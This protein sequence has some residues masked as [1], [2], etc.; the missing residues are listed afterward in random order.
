[1]CARSGTSKCEVCMEKKI[2]LLWQ[3]MREQL[4]R[5]YRVALMDFETLSESRQYVFKPLTILLVLLVVFVG[6][7]GGT[8]ALIVL[9]PLRE[10]IPGYFKSEYEQT[11]LVQRRL[12]DSL[13]KAVRD[14]E[15][16]IKALQQ[17]LG[18]GTGGPP[19][20]S[21]Q[22]LDQFKESVTPE[23]EAATAQSAPPAAQAATQPKMTMSALK[24]ASQ[25]ALTNLFPPLQGEVRKD[26]PFAFG[27]HYGVDIVAPLGAVIQSATEGVVVYADYSER[28]GYVIAVSGRN[29]VVTF[30]K[31]NARL[32]RQT[33]SYVQAGDPLAVIGNTG[34]NTSGPHLHFEL[35]H[36]G[37]PL[38]PTEYISFN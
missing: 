38:D 7:V 13:Q 24:S 19:T 25:S 27:T 6:L 29:N 15:A 23:T 2:K 32:L 26:N 34:E 5:Q 36:E 28:D 18:D 22:Q 3:Q 11:I 33:G 30:Y 4:H 37:K 14:Q 20:Q 9:T 21:M 35:W 1:M 8:A 16:V 10:H 12:A 31:H 17:A